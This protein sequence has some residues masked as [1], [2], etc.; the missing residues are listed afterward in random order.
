M[1]TNS[2]RAKICVTV[3]N[4]IWLLYDWETMS[5]N[6]LFSCSKVLPSWCVRIIVNI[7]VDDYVCLWWRWC[8]VDRWWWFLLA[9]HF[10]VGWRSKFWFFWSFF[11]FLL[12]FS[13][14]FT[15]Y[16]VRANKE[17]KYKWDDHQQ[18]KHYWV[19]ILFWLWNEH[20][21]WFNSTGV[22]SKV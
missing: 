3:T 6:L 17:N 2:G 4:D 13:S 18:F 14:I 21:T 22:N 10:C 12:I 8:R 7:V 9:V 1:L 5:G 16:K 19:A 20:K 15:T 11:F